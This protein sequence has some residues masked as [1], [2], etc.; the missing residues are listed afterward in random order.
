MKKKNAHHHKT[1][2]KTA[3]IVHTI[4]NAHILKT[5][6]IAG[7]SYAQD[8]FETT[9]EL[10][11]AGRI[12]HLPFVRTVDRFSMTAH[13]NRDL[14]FELQI[15]KEPLI[16]KPRYE[17]TKE[18]LKFGI[19][20]ASKLS[21][22][23]KLGIVYVDLKDENLIWNGREH[24]FIDFGS[25][26]LTGMVPLSATLLYCSPE[27]LRREPIDSRH[28]TY[29]LASIMIHK[30]TGV[31][32]NM[33]Y[34]SDKAVMKS[35]RRAFEAIKKILENSLRGNLGLQEVLLE[36]V[37]PDVQKRPMVNEFYRKLDEQVSS[38]RTRANVKFR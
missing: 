9:L 19:E 35:D 13:R 11:I 25:S 23:A 10:F 18:I 24:I 14:D 20:I 6:R 26:V 31:A 32:P 7:A 3:S 22:F 37:E 34:G 21:E 28:D 1:S 36:G 17:T 27:A 38:W 29:T 16:E 15:Q 5:V 8:L 4:D 2:S 30:L 12:S 33:V